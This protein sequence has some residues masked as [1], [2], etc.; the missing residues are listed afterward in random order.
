MTI[1]EKNKCL[2]LNLGQRIWLNYRADM[3]IRGRIGTIVGYI[4]HAGFIDVELD[5]IR[6][7]KRKPEYRV[8]ER[9]I[10]FLY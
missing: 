7:E 10:S 9:C 1:E 2:E 4:K 5:T 3:Q 8:K 6:N